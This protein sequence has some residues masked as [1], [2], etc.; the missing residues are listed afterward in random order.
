MTRVGGDVR[1][2][3]GPR[4]RTRQDDVDRVALGHL[5]AHPAP[6]ALDHHDVP[7]KAILAE[8][9][10]NR[11]QVAGDQGTDVRVHDRRAGALELPEFGQDLGGQLDVIVGPEGDQDFL[12]LLFV[13]RVGVAMQEADDNGLAALIEQSPAEPLDLLRIDRREDVALLVAPLVHLQAE[14]SRNERFEIA[15]QAVAVVPV[16]AADLEDVPKT[17]RG[18]E[19][20]F[21]ALALEDGVGRHGGA[22]DHHPDGVDRNSEIRQSVQEAAG[23]VVGRGEHLQNFEIPGLGVQTH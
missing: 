2:R 17:L 22:V 18:Q 11:A 19:S 12:G 10:P 20:D 4:R 1:R 16:P 9:L 14:I 13:G 21:G 8:L 5:Q 3:D 7:V 23:L 6:V 15:R